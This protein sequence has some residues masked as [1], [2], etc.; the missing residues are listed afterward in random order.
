MTEQ[1]GNRRPVV[2]PEVFTGERDFSHWI[3]HFESVAVV[4]G[5]EEN[6]VKLQ[7]LHVHVTGKAHVALT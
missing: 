5:W 1:T 6:F 3:R 2:L 4:N 7:W